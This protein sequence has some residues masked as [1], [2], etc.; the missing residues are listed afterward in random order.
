MAQKHLP[1]AYLRVMRYWWRSRLDVGVDEAC[2]RVTH[3]GLV[4]FVEYVGWYSHVNVSV[5]FATLDFN[6]PLCPIS[7]DCCAGQKNVTGRMFVRAMGLE[8]VD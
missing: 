8:C 6:R 7:S 5:L 4:P 1:H 3:Y 2:M